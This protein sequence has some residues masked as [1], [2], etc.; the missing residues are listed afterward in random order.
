M[1]NLRSPGHMRHLSAL[2]E[3]ALWPCGR[4]APRHAGD[5]ERRHQGAGGVF[6]PTGQS[7]AC[8]IPGALRHPLF[9]DVSLPSHAHRTART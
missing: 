6:D 1:G 8:F 3:H 9:A 2:D 4:G 7:R 5:L